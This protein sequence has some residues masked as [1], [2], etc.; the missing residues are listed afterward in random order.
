[1]KRLSIAAA[2]VIAIVAAGCGSS[3]KS[4]TSTKSTSAPVSS[5]GSVSVKTTALGPVLVDGSGRTLYMLT[6][7]K[8]G[9]SSCTSGACT[10]TWPPFVT[11]GAPSAGSGV[12]ASKLTVTGRPDG[13]RQVVYA[14]HPLYRFSGDSS[15]GSVAGQKISSF[16]GVWYV[17]SPAGNAVTKS[18]TAAPSSS[19]S[20]GGGNASPAYP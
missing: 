16:G 1:M 14:G 8:G 12:T 17:V 6:A 15:A 11:G 20:S 19:G 4:T 5:G 9:K 18:S 2:L 3:S 10:S 13:S 7:D